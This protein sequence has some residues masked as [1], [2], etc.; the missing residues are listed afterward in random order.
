MTA[1]VEGRLHP[2]TPWRRA[3]AITATV[4]VVV[5]RDLPEWTESAKQWPLWL[6][7]L[8]IASVAALASAYGTAHGARPPTD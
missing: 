7:G 3:W 6:P 8:L 4:A 1:I 5:L 2:I